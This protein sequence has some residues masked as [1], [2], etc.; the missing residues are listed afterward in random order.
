[1][2]T[3]FRYKI[4]SWLLTMHGQFSY[5]TVHTLPS[6][7]DF[8]NPEIYST[9]T[10]QSCSPHGILSIFHFRAHILIERIISTRSSPLSVRVY[11]HFTGNTVVSIFFFI[12]PSSSS[13]LS[14][15][16]RILGVISSSVSF[17][18]EN[19]L[20]Y[21]SP[22]YNSRMIRKVHFFVRYFTV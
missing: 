4:R 13:S 21:L 14:R 15:S 16:E 6:V 8:H 19:L 22:L 17:N 5:R 12:I 18:S 20:V 2:S 10:L 7:Q 9:H 11:S 1:M 3:V